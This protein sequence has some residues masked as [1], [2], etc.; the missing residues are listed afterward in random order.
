MLEREGLLDGLDDARER[1][2]RCE[3][4]KQLLDAGADMEQ[5]R[6]ATRENRLALLP[7]ELLFQRDCTMTVREVAK[8]TGLDE[9]L[10][11]SD[12]AI[13]GLPVP[14]SDDAALTE[15]DLEAFQVVR[16]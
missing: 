15:G 12:L 10:V 8:R 14:G 7:V 13:S 5:L 11:R 6:A 4:L 16:Q 3:L 1:E 9:E 2:A